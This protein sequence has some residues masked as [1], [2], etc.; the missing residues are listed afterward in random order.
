MNASLSGITR[1][2]YWNTVSRNP[3]LQALVQNVI[4]P[5]SARMV[6]LLGTEICV[7]PSR[8]TGYYRAS[9]SHA[10][11]QV[12][13]HEMPGMLAL[14]SLLRPGACFADCGANVGLWSAAAA[15]LAPI[16]P[17]LEVLAFEA[18]PD[19]FTRLSETLRPHKVARCFR[20]ALS[21]KE[22]VLDMA[23]GA[24]SLTFG[25]PGSRFN[26]GGRT[27]KVEAG[28]LDKYLAGHRDIVMKI[29][30]EEH[31]YEVLIG[32]TR[33]IEEGRV[34]AIM[35]DGLPEPTADRILRMMRANK[36]SVF[37]LRDLSPYD[38]GTAAVLAVR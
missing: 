37:N 15:R 7:I 24:S 17:G 16:H 8:E 14:L 32:A 5:S 1:F 19:T 13:E 26:K 11:R 2:L 20:I 3:R 31:E 35:I 30:V 36:F 21:D 10:G 9:L 6:P 33:A 12:F 18:N 29:D 34:R 27:V 25:V 4:F 28:P 23:E 38:G 22:G